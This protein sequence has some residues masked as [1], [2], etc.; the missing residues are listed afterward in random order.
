MSDFWWGH[1]APAKVALQR[2]GLTPTSLASMSP[3]QRRAAEA[4][5]AK[6]K[7][8]QAHPYSSIIR[9]RSRQLLA[10]QQQQSF[11]PEEVKA[12][13]GAVMER[14]EQ[15]MGGIHTARATAA[16]I[17]AAEDAPKQYVPMRP[18]ES[19]GRPAVGYT[20]P[21]QQGQAGGLQ[22]QQQ[23]LVPQQ[24]AGGLQRQ[25][26]QLV[27]QQEWEQG[28][29]QEEVRQQVEAE[30]VQGGQKGHVQQQ[31]Q[32]EEEQQ[33]V[34]Q[35]QEGREGQQEEEEQQRQE[36][37]IQG[38]QQQVV[39]QQQKGDEQQQVGATAGLVQK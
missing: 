20:V 3:P 11:T 19:W 32:Q 6:Y 30:L 33:A 37:A 5:V 12:A 21:Q 17:A 36:A 31:V 26:Q 16:S 2:Q 1:Y 28:Q 8:R 23:Q 22:G 13:A 14:L 38:Q 25:Q 24:Q 27:P 29:Q 39:P 9:R 7:P 10:A 4:T 15:N 34:L 35:Q 18:R